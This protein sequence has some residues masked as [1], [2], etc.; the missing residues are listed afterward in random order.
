MKRIYRQDVICSSIF[1]IIGIFFLTEALDLGRE[2]LET[3][4][5]YFPKL[6]SCVFI[7]LSAIY[8]LKSFRSNTNNNYFKNNNQLNK[9]IFFKTIGIILIFLIL[10]P[11]VPFIALSSI[12]LISL[13]YIF[14]ANFIKSL[15][16][17]ITTSTAI[18]LIFSKIFHVMLS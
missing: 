5:E 13:G 6:L 17:S 11:Y 12:Y 10:W 2:N 4:V 3:G 7:I 1:I 8:F 16:Y 9:N 14:K 15:V 18:Y